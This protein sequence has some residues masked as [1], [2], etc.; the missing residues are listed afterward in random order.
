M[1]IMTKIN[2]YKFMQAHSHTKL[3][4]IVLMKLNWQRD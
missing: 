2:S 3:K 1:E 4:A